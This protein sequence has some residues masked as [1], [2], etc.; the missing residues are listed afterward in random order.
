[1]TL[2]CPPRR[3]AVAGS[4]ERVEKGRTITESSEAA[5]ARKDAGWQERDIR[6]VAATRHEDAIL[7]LPRRSSPSEGSGEERQGPMPSVMRKARD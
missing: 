5:P 4:L 2:P 3:D 6:A 7:D 1:M